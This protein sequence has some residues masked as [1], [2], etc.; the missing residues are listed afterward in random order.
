MARKPAKSAAPP[1]TTSVSS[2]GGEALSIAAVNGTVEVAQPSDEERAAAAPGAVQAAAVADAKA[3]AE[4]ADAAPSAAIEVRASRPSYRRAGFVFADRDWTRIERGEDLSPARL[5][6]LLD[7][8]VLS[9]RG[10]A[11]NGEIFPFSNTDRAMFA[12]AIRDVVSA[13]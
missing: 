5:L 1:A 11:E 10:V 9:V 3:G 4:L 7:D 12:Q 8:P 2:A 13:D 6:A